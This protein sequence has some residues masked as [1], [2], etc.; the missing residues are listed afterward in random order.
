[1]LDVEAAYTGDPAAISHDE[2]IFSY[3]GVRT[4]I[5]HRISHEL[6]KLK[7]PLIPASFPSTPTAPRASTSIRAPPSTSGSSST[8]APGVVIGETCEIGRN[9]RIYQG[10]TPGTKNFPIERRSQTDESRRSAPFSLPSCHT[11]G[12]KPRNRVRMTICHLHPPAACANPIRPSES[13][14]SR[15][16]PCQ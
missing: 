15:P 5:Q 13:L 14:K 6:Y 1:M 12:G 2:V 11:P 16:S 10:A 3:P 7:I 9:V 4:I 8:T